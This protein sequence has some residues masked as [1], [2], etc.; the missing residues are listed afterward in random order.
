MVIQGLNDPITLLLLNKEAEKSN[1]W[2]RQLAEDAS[3]GIVARPPSSG[4]I[5][6]G[7]NSQ[8]ALRYQRVK[9]EEL[10]PYKG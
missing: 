2:D 7:L 6:E 9:G 4:G 10:K 5:V 3:R 8:A 1:K